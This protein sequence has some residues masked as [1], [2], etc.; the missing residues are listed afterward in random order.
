[1]K[2]I[3]VRRKF[4]GIDNIPKIADDIFDENSS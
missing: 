4:L 3:P 1:V 2:K